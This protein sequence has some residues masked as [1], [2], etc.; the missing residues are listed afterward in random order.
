ME[1]VPEKVNVNSVIQSVMNLLHASAAHKKIQIKSLINDNIYI[2]ADNQSINTVF[3]NLVSNAIK[4]THTKGL[5][6]IQAEQD[7]SNI[8]VSINDNGIG[9][10]QDKV[11][12]LFRYDT[13]VSTQG[14]NNEKGTGLGLLLCKEFVE[15]NNG[16]LT[17]ES[18]QGSGTTFF[19]K[20]PEY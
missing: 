15:Q 11:D 9:M 13:K 5:I 7:G 12:K 4:F 6:M 10:S 19:V 8:I 3:R 14:T 1:I 16:Q 18:I 2:V 20:L 17:V